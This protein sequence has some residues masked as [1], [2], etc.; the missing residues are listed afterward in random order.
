VGYPEEVTER[1]K[2][3]IDLGFDYFQ[4]MFPET[5]DEALKASQAFAKLVMNKL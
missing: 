4:V 5:G 2:F 3:F 1:F